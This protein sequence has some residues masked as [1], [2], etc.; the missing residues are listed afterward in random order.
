VFDAKRINGLMKGIRGQY[1]NIPS[2][3]GGETRFLT[4][5]FGVFSPFESSGRYASPQINN[6]SPRGRQIPALNFVS[7]KKKYAL[8]S[9][10]HPFVSF[11][12]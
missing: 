1:P 9:T 10:T 12:V 6:H 11:P 4:E 5:F 2:S 7:I 3:K 8:R